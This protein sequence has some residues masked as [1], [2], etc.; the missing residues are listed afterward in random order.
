MVSLLPCV[1]GRAVGKPSQNFVIKLVGYCL[2]NRLKSSWVEL[3]VCQFLLEQDCLFCDAKTTHKGSRNTWPRATL[4]DTKPSPCWKC[5]PLKNITR[6]FD[7]ETKM[8]IWCRCCFNCVHIPV[9]FPAFRGKHLYPHNN[10]VNMRA[11]LW[12][13]G[14]EFCA[15]PLNKSLD[16]M[17]HLQP[18]AKHHSW[19]WP[20]VCT[21]LRGGR[22]KADLHCSF[23]YIISAF[24]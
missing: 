16:G 8:W 9:V 4:H 19:I 12:G 2:W 14:S 6:T 20:H 23:Y 18:P 10:A 1:L 17:A 24:H 13:G 3:R 7:W 5:V 11:Q 22:S 15:P 21:L